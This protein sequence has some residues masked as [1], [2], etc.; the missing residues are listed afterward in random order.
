MNTVIF[1][2]LVTVFVA[3]F[4]TALY[5]I[6]K[7]GSDADDLMLGDDQYKGN[8]ELKERENE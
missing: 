7:C 6:L 3:I 5:S 1:F 2:S 4:Y 8:E